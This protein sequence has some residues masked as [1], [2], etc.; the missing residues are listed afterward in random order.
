MTHV[1]MVTTPVP[2]VAL[3]YIVPLA[4]VQVEVSS[5]RVNLNLRT[6]VHRLQ[7]VCYRARVGVWGGGMKV[8][9]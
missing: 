8:L 1:S 7:T 6:R 2:L 3:V 4:H 9:F 5:T